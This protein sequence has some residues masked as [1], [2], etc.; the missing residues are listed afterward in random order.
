M[1][2]I[3]IRDDGRGFSEEDL[4]KAGLCYYSGKGTDGSYHFGLGLYIAALLCGKHVGSL[5]IANAKEGGA[6]LTASFQFICT[7]KTPLSPFLSA[8]ILSSFLRS[9]TK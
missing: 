9:E 6:D 5:Q 8:Y 4:K 2:R 1:L 7:Y 3:N